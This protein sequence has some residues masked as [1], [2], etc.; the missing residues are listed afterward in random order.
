MRTRPS[1]WL[2]AAAALAATTGAARAEEPPVEL[3]PMT[4]TGV[5]N[6][7]DESR[8]RLRR[9]LQ[10]APDGGSAVPFREDWTATVA[11]YFVPPNPTIEERREA[12]VA[13]EWRVAEYGPEMEAFR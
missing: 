5:P 4:V 3:E 1:A 8:Q 2:L 6:P 11:R 12:R 10:D 13:N 7:L 9:L